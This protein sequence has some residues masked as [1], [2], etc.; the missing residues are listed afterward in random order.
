VGH[1]LL[2]AL[3]TVLGDGDAAI[4]DATGDGARALEGLAD[5]CGVAVATVSRR[6]WPGLV[7]RLAHAPVDVRARLV[8][9]PSTT[10]P[11]RIVATDRAVLRAAVGGR[12]LTA[13]VLRVPGLALPA[14][15][16]TNVLVLRPRGAT[17]PLRLQRLVPGADPARIAVSASRDHDAVIATWTARGTTPA[18]YVKLGDVAA[19]ARALAWIAPGAAIGGCVVPRV[20]AH[21]DRLL[22]TSALGGERAARVLGR[23]PA[24]LGATLERLASWLAAWHRAAATPGE[25]D[26]EYELLGPARRLGSHLAPGYADRLGR[27]SREL[28]GVRAP[29]APA[30]R[31]VTMVN[32][33]LD[34]D[35][36]GVLDWETAAPAALPFVDAPYAI[37]DAALAA[38]GDGDRLAAFAR[39]FGE[40][41]P[42][43]ELVRRIGLAARIEPAVL[44]ASFHACWLGHA[45]NEL[46]RVGPSGSFVAI[47]ARLSAAPDRVDPFAT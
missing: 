38:A 40:G 26:L 14:R 15:L 17:A 6:A 7:R 36:F 31:D 24:R 34:D 2:D 25:P 44:S 5:G 30:H 19:E 18:G 46:E 11:R 28:A 45:V 13:A 1:G 47:A 22:A 21:E 10:E 37:V 41:G 8:A 9:L 42:G 23:Q 16:A 3:G 39:C 4:V 35:A 33:L 43:R 32:V 12:P 29:L 20:L 27:L